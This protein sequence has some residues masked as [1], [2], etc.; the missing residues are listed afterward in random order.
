MS[1]L[2]FGV[3]FK[4]VG[5]RLSGERVERLERASRV[6]KFGVSFLDDCLGGIFPNDLI[7]LGAKTGVGKTALS[8]IIAHENV[9]AGK[10]VHYF[11]LEAEDRE[12]ERRMK[13]RELSDMM[14]KSAAA[15]AVRERL[16][17]VDWYA[18]RLDGATG[19]R[20]E[21]EIDNR[22]T[23]EFKTLNTYYRSGSFGLDE[24]SRLFLA[25]QD[26][27]DLII[28]DHLHY[29]DIED[30]NESRGIKDVVKRIRD[31]SLGLGKPVIVVAHLRKS[32]RRSPMLIPDLD[33]FHGS[34]DI[35][36]IATKCI[37]LAPARDQSSGEAHL[38][39]T[40]I[41]APKCRM[42]GSRTRYAGLVSFNSRMSTY[43][44]TYVLGRFNTMGTEFED[45][46]GDEKH[47]HWAASALKTGQAL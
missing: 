9:K 46:K 23:N 13:Y 32:D 42:E 2:D 28:L 34:S 3:G 31:I 44:S 19:E 21:Q 40:Y 7:V 16:N 41:H 25:I 33:D 5:E 39:P 26:Q 35:T 45:L 11:A 6:L 29:V 36:K 18:G 37:M 24:L 38:W 1:D 22:V 10:R 8:T 43:E 17:Y 27:T 12:I 15:R 30:P 14:W 47:P 20:I 4:G